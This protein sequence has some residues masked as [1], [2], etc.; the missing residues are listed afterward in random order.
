MHNLELGQRPVL[1]EAL[2]Y[3]MDEGRTRV[4]NYSGNF[5]ILPKSLRPVWDG[6]VAQMT[7]GD[8]VAIHLSANFSEG[9]ATGKEQAARETFEL[10]D[11]LVDRRIISIGQMPLWEAAEE[12]GHAAMA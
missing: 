11:L 12:R 1:R 6:I 7:V 9:D 5:I 4:A 8:L 2:Y 3:A 10:L